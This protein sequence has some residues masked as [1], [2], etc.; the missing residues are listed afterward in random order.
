MEKPFSAYLGNEEFV[1]V[2]YAHDDADLVYADLASL[3]DAGVRVWYDEGI[4]PGAEWTEVLADALERCTSV[5]YFVSSRSVDSQH[6]RREINYT[7]NREKPITAVFLEPTNRS[8][9]MPVD[10]PN[11]AP[12][13]RSNLSAPEKLR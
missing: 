7:L 12:G 2:C 4:R 11:S 13:H 1:F 3:R 6:C 9:T 5:L 8:A 10:N